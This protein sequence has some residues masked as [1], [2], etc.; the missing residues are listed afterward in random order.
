M[1]RRAVVALIAGLYVST[2]KLFARWS[3]DQDNEPADNVSLIRVIANPNAFDG[4][5]L[6]IVGYLD[7]NGTDRAIGIYVSEMDGRNFVIW[8]SVDLHINPSVARDLSAKYVIFLGTYH[9]PDPRA[10]YNGY[11]DHVVDL[12]LWSAG[13]ALKK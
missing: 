7:R 8:N 5:R 12:K 9:A 10:G 6:T 11:F 3:P 4:R 2:A 13:D 1:T